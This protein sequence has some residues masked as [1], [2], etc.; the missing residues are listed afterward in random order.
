MIVVDYRPHKEETNCTRLTV[1][2]NL[3]FYSSTVSSP[4]S[5]LTTIKLLWN[6]V[7]YTPGSKFCVMDISNFYLGTKMD[8]YEY[9][10]LPIDI[11]PDTLIKDYN[12]T[13][14]SSN[15]KVYVRI[16]KGI[17]GIP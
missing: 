11:I 5:D 12:L 6:S 4:T 1:G 8:R 14:I 9:M 15:G 17:Y 3:I 7:I 10:V 16:E 13:D 2:V